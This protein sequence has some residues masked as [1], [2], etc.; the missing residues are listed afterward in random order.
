MI[1]M[2]DIYKTYKN[3]VTALNGININID[4][5]EFVY[6]VG[7]SGAGKSTFIKLMYREEK[8]S[9][10]KIIIGE[11][12]LSDLK[13]KHVPFLR[14]DIGVIFQDFKLLP[15]L[16]A[17]E[18]VAFAL[19]VIEES[20]KVIRKQ[21]MDVLEMVGLKNKARM[22]PSELSGGEQQ[23][24]SIARAIVNKP[25]IVIADEP[26]GNLDP[27]TSWG[28]M[29]LFEEINDRGTTIIMATHSKDIVDRKKKRVIAFE[30]GVIARDEQRGD[31]GYEV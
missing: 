17:Y 20:P 19:E 29:E 27:E 11:K 25:R 15:K 21:V 30:D 24:V 9:K 3:G 28:I 7:P 12:D 2:Q 23:R 26:T 13:E 31:Y 5:G 16:T 18:N 8:P 22:I 10:G 14:R 4:Q 6:I 1:L